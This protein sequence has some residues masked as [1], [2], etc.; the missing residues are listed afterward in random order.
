MD[1]NASAQLA[2]EQSTPTSTPIT[3]T[4]DLVA[5]GKKVKELYGTMNSAT[6]GRLIS[7]IPDA[8]AGSMF[9]LKNG[10][11]KLAALGINPTGGASAVN[12]LGDDYYKETIGT[13]FTEINK[14][15]TNMETAGTGGAGDIS[16]MY[17]YIK[18]LDPDSAVR[19]GELALA[20]KAAGLPDNIIKSAKK[21]DSK[22]SGLGPEMRRQMIA[23]G[24]RIYNNAAGKQQIIIDNYTNKAK[25]AGIDPTLVVGQ[26]LK[27]KQAELPEFTSEEGKDSIGGLPGLALGAAD[28]ITD[29]FTSRTKKLFTGEKT[30]ILKEKEVAR[31]A[32]NP[33]ER[34]AAK[35]DLLK[36]AKIALGDAPGMFVDTAKEAYGPAI[37][38]YLAS[39]GLTAFIGKDVAGKVA[40]KTAPK[41]GSKVVKIGE[42]IESMLTKNVM[43]RRQAEAALREGG[44]KLNV[45][46]IIDAG[47]K[48]AKK[49]GAEKAWAPFKKAIQ[50]STNPSELVD[51]MSV[52]N[53]AYSQSGQVAKT[54]LAHTL[55]AAKRAA[56]EV[57]K[58]GA[59]ETAEARSLLKYSYQVP[60]FAGKALWKA[61]LGRIALGS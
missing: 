48:T 60:K 20:A 61:T 50:Q 25:Y 33:E 44:V 30:N 5:I 32:K 6:D 10:V 53:K 26:N 23:E 51:T 45:K 15:W 36:S 22:G 31:Q 21:L 16:I 19:E 56:D 58:S 34:A 52:L 13:G 41:L 12:S 40:L 17:S 46:P 24:A 38:L 43:G 8:E 39:R 42:K 29:F 1:P 11:D 57:L 7:T 54:T 28:K 14:Q 59:P 47:E 35:G 2:V 4:Q 55:A 18:M 37:D 3:G 27:L 49:F 9:I